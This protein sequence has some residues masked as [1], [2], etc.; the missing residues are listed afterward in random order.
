MDKPISSPNGSKPKT[1]GFTEIHSIRDEGVIAVITKRDDTDHLSFSILKEY[2]RDGEVTRS[3]FLNRRH[4]EPAQR[5]LKQTLEFIDKLNDKR[6]SA[7]PVKVP[8]RP[9]S[10]TIP[11]SANTAASTLSA[12]TIQL[13]GRK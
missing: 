11:L 4:G 7:L 12:P 13:R 9:M 10:S 5:V 8:P 6:T 3:S 2:S 1:T